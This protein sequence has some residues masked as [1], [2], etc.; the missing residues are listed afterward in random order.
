MDTKVTPTRTNGYRKARL[1][2][3]HSFSIDDITLARLH[4]IRQVTA[5]HMDVEHSGSTIVRRAMAFYSAHV[6][7]LV[8]SLRSASKREKAADQL[9]WEGYYLK[10]SLAGA[11]VP[12]TTLPVDAGVLT[13]AEIVGTHTDKRRS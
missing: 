12:F 5:T 7:S 11:V 6:D 4:H 8:K 1:G 2:N 13:F 3:P 10:R 9:A